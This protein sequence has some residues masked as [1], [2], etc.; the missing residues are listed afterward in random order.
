VEAMDFAGK[1]KASGIEL[2]ESLQKHFE[3]LNDDD[4]KAEEET[5]AKKADLG[6]DLF[7]FLVLNAKEEV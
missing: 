4:Q 6:D 7:D 5:E 1:I 3:T 2:S